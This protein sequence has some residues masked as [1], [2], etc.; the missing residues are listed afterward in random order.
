MLEALARLMAHSRQM[1]A[2]VYDRR[3]SLEKVNPAL[4]ALAL[5]QPGSLPT[6]P[7]KPIEL[8]RVDS[9]IDETDKPT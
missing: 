8:K 2:E 9:L 4:E 6:V 3:T 7:L 5:I 1:Q